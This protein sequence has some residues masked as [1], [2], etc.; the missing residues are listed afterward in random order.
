M[1]E[2]F[3]KQN[4]TVPQSQKPVQKL[5]MFKQLTVSHNVRARDTPDDAPA[6]PSSSEEEEDRSGE[7][8]GST[9][10]VDPGTRDDTTTNLIHDFLGRKARDRAPKS[11]P[12]ENKMQ[13]GGL[14]K[15]KQKLVNKLGRQSD[16]IPADDEPN[17]ARGLI[18]SD[19]PRNKAATTSIPVLDFNQRMAEQQADTGDTAIL[20]PTSISPPQESIRSV[21]T[22]TTQNAPGVVQNAFERM[23]PRR[24]PLETATITIGPRTFTSAIGSP[25]RKRHRIHVVTS[26]QSGRG[27]PMKQ[28]ASQNFGSTLQAFAAPGTLDQPTASDEDDESDAESEHRTDASPQ[29]PDSPWADEVDYSAASTPKGGDPIADDSE[30]GESSVDQS[31]GHDD[32]SSDD[33]YMDEETKKAKEER[34]VDQM[35]HVAEERAAR[36]SDD[37]AKRAHR[38]LKGGGQKDS[39]VQL[40]CSTDTS[41]ERITTQ[42]QT[43]QQALNDSLRHN[44][45]KD[46][47]TDTD[48]ESAEE[49]LSLTVTKGDF[50]KMRIV[51]QFNLGFILA[52]RSEPSSPNPKDPSIPSSSGDELFI[53]DQHASDEKYNFECLQASTIVQNQR[54]VRPRTLDLTAIEEEIILENPAAL[55]KN[56]FLVDVD[57]TGTEPVGQRC[58]LLSLPMSREVTFDTRDL[59][60]L[61]AL[62]AESPTST[63]TSTSSIPRP[64]KVR[65]MFAMRACRSSVMIGK[66]LTRRQME[67]LVRNMGTIDKPWN[68]PHGR[69]TMRH[70]AGLADW[71]GWMEGQGVEGAGEEVGMVDWK[72]WVGELEAG[73]ESIESEGV[74]DDGEVE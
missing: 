62:L 34:R 15:G 35:I 29:D 18:P 25:P 24:S 46:I 40:V 12:G 58:K 1:T 66:T 16:A 52:T 19:S 51:G 2:L 48:A 65:R 42:L 37:S 53:I 6:N 67:R 23:R 30:A 64:S 27:S 72:K 63:S 74:D 73:G 55:L 38:L 26:R 56:G 69:P 50:A 33:E 5:P 70:L 11:I 13:E 43:L 47:G 7:E 68:C 45:S 9:K 14:S 39:T 44:K 22:T 61:L 17:D 60:E 28:P 57:Q 49:R 21:D 20:S 41:I 36:P 31:M 10:R 59:E 54:L 32:G 8:Y 71:D 4:Q 3:E